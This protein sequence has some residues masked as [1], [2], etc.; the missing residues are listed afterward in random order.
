M[1]KV[2]ESRKKKT[3][4]RR[5][6]TPNKI[7]ASMKEAVEKAFNELGGYK[8]LVECAKEDPRT[9]I[10]LARQ[11]MPK[12]IEA[13]IDMTGNIDHNLEITFRGSRGS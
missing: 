8:W 9:F 12:Q 2:E 11:L 6:G 1:S 10:P 7:N 3:G 5:K 4:G 13:A